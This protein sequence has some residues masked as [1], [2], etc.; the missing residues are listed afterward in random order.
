MN[1][2][3]VWSVLTVFMFQP[4]AIFAVSP[5]QEQQ[6]A[7]GGQDRVRTL[8]PT[9]RST[10]EALPEQKATQQQRQGREPDIKQ[11][12]K[13]GKDQGRTPDPGSN[14]KTGTAE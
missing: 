12:K 8:E 7:E 6:R 13:H 4:M 1:K 14:A 3:I 9:N 2:A 5:I 11:G 10:D